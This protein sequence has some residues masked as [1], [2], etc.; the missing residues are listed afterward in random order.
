MI[1]SGL[2]PNQPK[3]TKANPH[4]LSQA[5]SATTAPTSYQLGTTY[6]PHVWEPRDGTSKL[7]CYDKNNNP[8]YYDNFGWSTS[9]LDDAGTN[10]SLPNGGSD[11]DFFRLCGPGATD[12]ALEYW[13]APPNSMNSVTTDTAPNPAGYTT[14]TWHGTDTDSVFRMRGYMMYLAW[15][16]HP[17]TWETGME[18]QTNYP[19]AG[20]TLW[21]VQRALNWEASGENG[22]TWVGYFYVNEWWNSSTQSDFHYDVVT[23]ISS[24]YVPVV[25]EVNAGKLPNWNLST[26]Q[27]NHFITIIG[28]NDTNGTYTY[29]DTCGLS[30]GCNTGT[31][32]T[33]GGT[34]TV[35]QSTMWTAITSVP[36]NTTDDATHGDGGWVW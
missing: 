13:P 12:V 22:S 23:D 14:T 16:E 29:L 25:A 3:G 9:P 33:D 17:P 24:S 10:Y 6:T 30:T 20:S 11:A 18:D 2:R 34:H 4:T 31:G 7:C 32:G 26:Q 35:S 27:I 28:Y 8:L 15:E 21:K 36:V 1:V 19:S 5:Y